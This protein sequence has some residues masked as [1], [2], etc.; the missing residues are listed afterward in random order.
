MLAL[1]RDLVG[2][3]APYQTDDA[4]TVRDDSQEARDQSRRQSLSALSQNVLL[5]S[6]ASE[7]AQRA[8]TLDAAS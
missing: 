8:K 1:L 6:S 7:L 5:L 2:T 3:L 4:S